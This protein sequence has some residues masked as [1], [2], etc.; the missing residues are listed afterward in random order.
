MLSLLLYLRS[1]QPEIDNWTPPTPKAKF[2]GT[3]RRWLA[4]KEVA[5]WE[6]GLRI[7][8]AL[9]LS[10]KQEPGESEGETGSTVRP[11]IRRAHW[12]ESLSPGQRYT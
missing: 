6:V 5:P 7:G 4:A 1:E 9:D 8:R 12:H 3:K 11:H 2:F 10:A